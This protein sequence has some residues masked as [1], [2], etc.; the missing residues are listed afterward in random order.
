MMEL[1][2]DTDR[3]QGDGKKIVSRGDA[4]LLMIAAALAAVVTTALS[5]SGIAGYFT[6]PVTLEL[7]VSS[8]N[9]TASGLGLGATGHYTTL[10]ATIP[11]LPSEPAALLA[12]SAALDQL[13]VLAILTLVF[14]LAYRLRSA[15]LFSA[16]SVWIIGACGVVLALAG[17]VGQVLNGWGLTRV[18]DMVAG[19]GRNPGESV[20]LEAEFTT[21]PLMLGIVLVL[22][23]AVF[24]YGRRLQKDTEGLV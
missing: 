22:V 11:S 17:T 14:L 4:I 7:P 24:Q 1:A 2:K 21:G 3:K 5:V 19:T 6:G 20:I 18:A 15:V 10:S 8:T 23:A 9:Q 13:G 16:K 12:W